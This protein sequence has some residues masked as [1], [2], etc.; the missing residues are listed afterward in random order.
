MACNTCTGLGN[1]LLHWVWCHR[2]LEELDQGSPDGEITGKRFLCQFTCPYPTHGRKLAQPRDYYYGI[3]CRLARSSADVSYRGAVRQ[4]PRGGN[5]LS[6]VSFHPQEAWHTS[7]GMPR[8]WHP[9]ASG[10]TSVLR[11]PFPSADLQ[12][13]QRAG[14]NVYCSGCIPITVCEKP[15]RS[16]ASRPVARHAGSIDLDMGARASMTRGAS[17]RE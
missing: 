15:V 3:R 11:Q 1:R 16:V 8:R 13:W 17:V 2:V 7:S 9:L 14:Q 6:G 5:T 10:P 4:C 12:S